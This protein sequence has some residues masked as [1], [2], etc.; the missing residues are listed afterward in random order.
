[1]D[2]LAS[3][4]QPSLFFFFFGSGIS[5]VLRA[6]WVLPEANHDGHLEDSWVQIGRPLFN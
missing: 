6:P 2:L 4:Q 3:R 1:M 5:R